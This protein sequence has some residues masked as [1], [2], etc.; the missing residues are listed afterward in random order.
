MWE[1]HVREGGGGSYIIEELQQYLMVFAGS[2]GHHANIGCYPYL[3]WYFLITPMWIVNMCNPSIMHFVLF[4][5]MSIF[6]Q[7]VCAI[8][9]QN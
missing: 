5:S 3:L 6:T 2:S 1:S 9:T 7:Y 4:D 8:A